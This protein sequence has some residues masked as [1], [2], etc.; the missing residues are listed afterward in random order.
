MNLSEAL[1]AA[2]PEIPKSQ[3]SRKRPPMLDP[4]LIVREDTVDGEPVF[5]VYQRSTTNLFR[6]APMQWQLAM[7]F[8][9]RKSYEDIATAF[10]EGT[11]VPIPAEDVRTFA[12]NMD[13]SNFW[14]KTAQEK[15]IALNEKLQA[16]RGR[17]NRTGTKINPAHMTFS[18]WDP[19]RYLT[20]LDAKIGK[21]VYSRWFVTFAV[22]LFIFE[23]FVFVA[24]WSVLGPDIPL[25]YNFT[26]KSFADL[27]EFWILF[28]IIGFFHETAHGLTCKHY[29]GEVHSM[30][31]MFLYLA[32]AFYVDVTE[33]WV[34]ATRLQR[35]ATII[36]GIW[37]EM[38]ICGMAMIIWTNTPT[39]SPVHDFSYEMILITGL[40]VVV[41][42]LNPLIKLDGYYFLT[43]WIRIP[44]LKERST[45]FLSG[46]VQRYIFRLPVEVPVV[47]RRRVALFSAYAIASGCYSY[48]LLGAVIRFVFNIFS[49]W[50]AE[51]ALIPAGVLAFLIFRSRLR[52]LRTFFMNFYRAR[53]ADGS[54]RF[55]PWRVT[56]LGV[57][58]VLLLVPVWH[59][60][61][62]AYYLVEPAVVQVLRAGV[63][64]RVER[65]DVREGQNV[66]RGEVLATLDS[67][68][69]AS[70]STDAQAGLTRADAGL[71]EAE[72]RHQ[73]LGPAIAAQNGAVQM[74]AAANSERV[75][76][77]IKAPFDGVV[78]TN[79]PENL[80]GKD[81]GQGE[82]LIRIANGYQQVIRIFVPVSEVDHV[83][84][85][86]L[87][88][89]DTHAAFRPVSLRLAVLDGETATLTGGILR[90]QQ[91]K[92]IELPLFYSARVQVDDAVPDLKLGMSGHAKIFDRR[93]SVAARMLEVVKNL[94]GNHIW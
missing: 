87:V 60:R 36:A 62:D 35:L 17:R 76:Q 66:S 82:E 27:A 90:S 91:Y 41:V 22:L 89:L 73:G 77:T 67:L 21:H 52:S 11:G 64:G 23:A 58:A 85:G 10:A 45:G 88:A 2:L 53:S 33:A 92:G 24:K 38:I 71:F 4:D 49:H 72:L 5:A 84:T 61:E 63:P 7:L 81:V 32:P 44:D 50:V 86:D 16:Q 69:Y 78:M 15:N 39:G 51:W 75:V 42:N 80:A 37:V 20:R 93:R 29:G 30:G 70:R 55:T 25:Y 54:L 19:D 43:E 13:E 74:Q 14:H 79:A 94:I 1:D 59:D 56:V 9:G 12:A 48:L 6:F 18:A 65:V 83:H 3:L 34:A 68:T 57:L 46:W 26:K 40:A 28:L 8:D 47:P 31:L